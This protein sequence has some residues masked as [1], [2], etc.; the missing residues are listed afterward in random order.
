MGSIETQEAAA[1]L[2]ESEERFR[3]LFETM[4]QGVVYQNAQGEIVSANPAAE[5]ILGLTLDQIRGPISGEARGRAIH[6]DG[7]AFDEEEL[8]A[9]AALRSG[10]PVR[11]VVLGVYAPAEEQYRWINASAVPL[12]REGE[13][14]PY[15]VYSTFDDITERKH[16]EDAARSRERQLLALVNSLDDI[17]FEV[18]RQGAYVNVWM[19]NPA[20][21]FL[22]PEEFIGKRFDE[23]FGEEGSRPFF[24]FLARTLA[25]DAPQSLEYSLEIGGGQRWFA[26]RYSPIHLDGDNRNTVSIVVRDITERKQAEQTLRA[27]EERFRSLAEASDAAIVLLDAEGR[28]HYLNERSTMVGGTPGWGVEEAINKTVSELLPGPVA[29]LYLSR[30]RQVIAT[31]QSMVMES[32]VG[33]KHYRISIQPTHDEKGSAVLALFSAID[34]TALKAVQQE[35][36]ELNRS[37]EERVRQRTA[38]V[39]DLYDNAPTGYHSLDANGCFVQVNQ[40]ELNWLGYTRAELIGSSFTDILTAEGGAFFHTNF[41]YFKEHGWVRDVEYDFVRKDGSTFPVLLNAVAVYDEQGTFLASRGTIFDNTERKRADQ[42]LRASE[43]AMRLANGEMARALRMKDEF[44]ANMSHELRTPLHG[45]LTVSETLV[46]QISGPLNERQQKSVRLIDES[47]RHLLALINDLL[48]LSKIEAG[49]LELYYEV[50]PVDDICWAT[51]QFVR[52]MAAKKG[53]QVEYAN[54]AP[55]TVLSADVQRLKQML[56]NL[57]SNAVKFTPNGGQV[58]LS[59][60]VDPRARL[61]QFAVQDTGPGIPPVDQGR[62]FQPF[63][64]VDAQLSR[65]YEGTGLGLALVKRLAEQHG[66][67]VRLESTGVP[68][69]GCRFTVTLPHEPPAEQGPAGGA[70]PELPANPVT[71][72]PA[73]GPLL[74]LVEDNEV[75]IEVVGEYLRHAG[76]R[77]AVASTG[78]EALELAAAIT[79]DLI[80]MDVQLPLLDGLE[81]TRRLR[82]QGRFATTPI[83]AVTASA[84]AGDR[85][86]CL[87][88]GATDYLSKPLKIKELLARVKHWTALPA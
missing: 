87:A 41:P 46:D 29:D 8:P 2:R 15:Q 38:E 19:S 20:A 6:E 84:M 33:S 65:R 21:L 4:T 30:I 37:L 1:S 28:V 64:Q 57:L 86:R 5:R 12:F 7:S 81:V 54:A 77:V 52:E 35:L 11:N 13:S 32:S 67:T 51:L 22:P 10:Q 62:L 63:V 80:L 9:M 36:E 50:M 76:C 40:T 55:G 71:E 66:G 23:V 18:D 14:T 61:I 88:A 3:S 48:D 25:A 75:T 72:L 44:L 70:G 79:P 24:E 83:I 47:G 39:Q 31:D 27:S 42:A 82:A 58:R 74:L 45:I 73:A 49:K 43:E 85:E 16:A 78:P 68:G 17:V 53:I 56:V 26:A 69:E 60:A 34:I 59:V